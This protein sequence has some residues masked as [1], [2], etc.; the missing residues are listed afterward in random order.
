[1]I[2]PFLGSMSKIFR[3]KLN[4]SI[5]NSLLQR[6]IKVILLSANHLSF[7]FSFKNVILKELRSHLVYTFSCSSC[8]PT[9]YGKT[10]RH[11]NVKSGEQKGLSSL[12]GNRVVCKPS[13]IQ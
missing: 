1:M 3:Q 6:N 12:A 11:L 4:T 7:L 13:S 2:L 10:K 8:N 9:Y 5:Q